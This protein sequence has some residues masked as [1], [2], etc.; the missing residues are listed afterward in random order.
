MIFDAI[1]RLLDYGVKRNIITMDDT[2]FVRNR[3]MDTLRLASWEDSTAEAGDMTID[4]ILSPILDYAIE[5]G[6]IADTSASR[7][8][9]D[10]RI[11]GLM[12]PMPREVIAD[13]DKRYEISP[14]FA[15][16]WFYRFS[17]DVNYVRAGRI[18]KDL[19]WKYNSEYGDPAGCLCQQNQP[20]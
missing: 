12:M 15:T 13:F 3:M 19:K 1:S 6:I 5:Q 8:L 4:E 10:T 16:E 11:M 2:I 9:F 14:D 7:D 18:K 20:H 17:Q